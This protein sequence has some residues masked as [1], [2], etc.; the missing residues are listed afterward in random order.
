MGWE[1]QAGLM[2]LTLIGHLYLQDTSI[3]C[4]VDD[5]QLL[6]DDHVIKTQTMCGS[7]FIKPIEAEC[8]V[9]EEPLCTLASLSLN[10]KLRGWMDGQLRGTMTSARDLLKLCRRLVKSGHKA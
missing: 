3:L 9:R 8:R 6:L 2:N 10:G 5:I 1:K 7:V 4:A